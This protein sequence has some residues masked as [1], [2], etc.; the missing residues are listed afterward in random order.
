[1]SRMTLST[2]VPSPVATGLRLISTGNSEPSRR[3]PQRSSPGS[4][5][6]NLGLLV[7]VLAMQ[8]VLRPLAVGHQHFYALADQLVASVAEQGF[9][10]RI[11]LNDYALLVDGGDGIRNRLENA[12]R[13]QRLSHSSWA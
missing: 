8:V 4:H 13:Q 10:L 9:G 7:E 5:A 2:I 12:G 3:R 1:M 11:N 6:A